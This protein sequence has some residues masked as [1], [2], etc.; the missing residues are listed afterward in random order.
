MDRQLIRTKFYCLNVNNWDI[1]KHTIIEAIR[2]ENPEIVLL[3]DHSQRN[4]NKIKFWNYNTI[5]QNHSNELHDGTL[6]AIRKDLIYTEDKTFI[7][8]MLAINIHT[9]RGIITIAT[10]YQPPRRPHLLRADFTTLFRCQNPTFLLADLNARCSETGY[11]RNFNQQGRNL[12]AFLQEGL[13][14]RLG[15]DF[16]TFITNRA[17]TTPDIILSNCVGLPNYWIRPGEP[18]S[19]DHQTIL[20]DISWSPIQIPAKPRKQFKKANWQLYQNM[21]QHL[22]EKDIRNGSPTNTIEETLKEIQ[23]TIQQADS[24]SI[25]TASYRLLPHPSYSLNEKIQIQRLVILNHLIV[26]HRGAPQNW[27]L[28]KQTQRQ[29]C[30]KNSQHFWD[31]KILNMENCTDPKYFWQQIRKQKVLNSS[32]ICTYMIITGGKFLKQLTRN[33]FLENSSKQF[34]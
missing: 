12:T 32:P 1:N 27:I 20:M 25:P 33:L 11:Q 29:A 19:S 21:I 23:T 30:K 34:T 22:K 2:Q 24:A 8:E 28:M 18:T 14:R 6:I 10:A 7:E 13:C 16:P 26:N 4:S 15:P 17:A 5:Q 9:H 3:Q 31:N